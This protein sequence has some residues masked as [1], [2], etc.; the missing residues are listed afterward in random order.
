MSPNPSSRYIGLQTMGTDQEK[1]VTSDLVPTYIITKEKIKCNS[2][3]YF[4][5][6]DAWEKARRV[7]LFSCNSILPKLPKWE[8][9]QPGAQIRDTSVSCTANIA[10]GY[11]R[12]H[13]QKASNSIGYP[14]LQCMN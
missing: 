11:R 5:T 8:T 7:K 9:C 10:E 12:Y 4:T 13:Y 14:V 6:L 3:R 1:F 2:D